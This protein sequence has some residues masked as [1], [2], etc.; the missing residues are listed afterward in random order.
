MHRIGEG[1]AEGFQL[2]PRLVG[3]ER[4]PCHRENK[5]PLR[6]QGQGTRAAVRLVMESVLVQLIWSI[7]FIMQSLYC[8]RRQRSYRHRPSVKS[9]DIVAVSL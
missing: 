1:N 5:G 8:A 6:R 7:I 2:S 3:R 9:E 4:C